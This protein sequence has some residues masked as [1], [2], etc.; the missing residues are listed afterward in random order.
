MWACAAPH[1]RAGGARGQAS[2]N[3]PAQRH[4]NICKRAE[5]LAIPRKSR[6]AGQGPEA[7]YRR[8]IGTDGKWKA[9]LAECDP[10]AKAVPENT[11]APTLGGARTLACSIHRRM[12]QHHHCNWHPFSIEPPIT[13]VRAR[14][15]VKSR[16]VGAAILNRET[17]QS[18]HGPS[19]ALILVGRKARTAE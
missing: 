13:V 6:P 7:G 4:R 9:V 11:E 16:C 10:F 18:A 1:A 5:Q 3:R 8:A 19:F 14:R 17:D 12:L 2:A 15:E